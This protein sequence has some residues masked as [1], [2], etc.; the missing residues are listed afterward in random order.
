MIV[1]II[2]TVMISVAAAGVTIPLVRR[3]DA[4]R[5]R[6]GTLGVLKEQLRNIDAQAAA[7]ALAPADA[8][9]LRAETARRILAEGARAQ[10]GARPLGQRA[11]LVLG[12][13]LAASIAVAATV[14][15]SKIG[16]PDLAVSP[17]PAPAVS[18]AD[19][20]EAD[21]PGGGDIAGMI[22]QLEAR[23]KQSPGDPEGWRML[24][25][26][27]MRTGRYA[28]AA[29]AYGR[30]A[31]L[32]P[33]SAEY[34]SAQ[35]EALT[36]ASAGEVTPAALKAF[37]QAL[38]R[39]P[40]DPRARYFLAMARD[41]RG[42]HAGAMADWIAL[43]K[44]APPDAPW[45]AQVRGLVEGIAKAHGDDIGGRLPPAPAP[46]AADAQGSVSAAPAGPTADQVAAAGRMAPADQGAMIRGMVEG[47]ASRL[48]ANPRDADGWLRLM[49]ARMVLG[50]PADAASAYRQAMSAYADSPTQQAAFRAAAGQLGIPGA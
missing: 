1:W 15:Y 4:R 2:L 22:G 47:L 42:D 31:A 38:A 10:A 34:L 27:Y 41:Q 46:T 17:Q 11:L 7:Q 40:A 39:D 5:E 33:A 16:R 36:Q 29:N 50:D 19:G 25:W 35:G 24:G 21:H 12:L 9:V 32:D 3:Y 13:G 30:A 18:S 23:M 49:R 28:Q 26:S 43:L 37:G 45:A 14:L 48:K 8:E 44:N 20:A 6:A